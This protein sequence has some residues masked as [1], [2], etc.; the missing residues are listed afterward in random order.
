MLPGVRRPRPNQHQRGGD[1]ARERGRRHPQRRREHVMPPA[2]LPTAA[3][4]RDHVAFVHDRRFVL[5]HR[6][7]Y[8]RGLRSNAVQ[9]NQRPV[10]RRDLTRGRARSGRHRRSV[11]GGLSARWVGAPGRIRSTRAR[12]HR[13]RASLP[14]GGAAG[15]SFGSVADRR[16][17]DELH[18][19]LGETQVPV[20]EV[21]AAHLG[22]VHV[23]SLIAAGSSSTMQPRSQ[24]VTTRQSS[25]RSTSFGTSDPA[26]TSSRIASPHSPSPSSPG[27]RKTN[28]WLGCRRGSGRGSDTSREAVDRPTEQCPRFSPARVSVGTSRI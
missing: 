14:A 12:R 21:E 11:H 4:H 28:C 15:S 19:R 7:R 27:W 24:A 5:R 13:S 3:E 1:E 25:T 23:V 26:D 6:L 18:V 20:R 22:R 8:P 9:A 2:S 16:L 17:S 10:Q